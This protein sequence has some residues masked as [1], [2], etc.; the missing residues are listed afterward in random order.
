MIRLRRCAAMGWT[1]GVAIWMGGVLAMSSCGEKSR[2]AATRAPKDNKVVLLVIDGARHTEAF[3]DPV[4]RYVPRMWNDLRP[5]GAIIREFRNDGVTATNPGHTSLLTGTWQTIA[6]D[7]SERPTK[8][9]LFE[10]YREARS[11]AQTEVCVVGGKAKLNACSYSSH[12]QYGAAYGASERAEDVDDAI[13]YEKVISILQKEKPR[14]LM[15]SFSMVDIRAHDNDWSGYV[16]ALASVDS[17]VYELWSYLQADSFYADQTYLVV[18]NDHGRHD[19]QHGGFQ[20]H[21]DGCEGCRRLMFLALGPTIKSNYSADGIYGQRDV[22]NTIASILG[23]S[24]VL[25]E[26]IVIDEI[27]ENR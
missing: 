8:P 19:D 12:P 3:D 7:G 25:S 6:N 1:L 21:D 10:Y 2:T 18:T 26:G 27:F 16:T 20:H 5:R 24:A 13:L 11:V 15:A 4:H 17:L 22:C 9:T 23:F 14:L